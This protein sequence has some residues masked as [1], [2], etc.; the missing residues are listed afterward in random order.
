MGHSLE[1][2]SPLIIVKEGDTLEK[3]VGEGLKYTATPQS[4]A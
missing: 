2:S 3:L 4:N 1:I